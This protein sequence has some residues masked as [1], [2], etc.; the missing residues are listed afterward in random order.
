MYENEDFL[1]GAQ[2]VNNGH[3]PYAKSLMPNNEIE[4]RENKQQILSPTEFSGDLHISEMIFGILPRFY[5][6]AEGY[7]YKTQSLSAGTL[8]V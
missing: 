3:T 7:T 2:L 6:S 8:L 4:E 1:C 5:I